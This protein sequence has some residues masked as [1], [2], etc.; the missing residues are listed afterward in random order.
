MKVLHVNLTVVLKVKSLSSKYPFEFAIPMLTGWQLGYGQVDKGCD[1]ARVTEIGIQIDE[2]N[3]EK[4]P[5]APAGTLRYKLSTAMR[6]KKVSRTLL[7]S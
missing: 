4:T 7:P 3:Y 2:W 1:D 5:G 6:D